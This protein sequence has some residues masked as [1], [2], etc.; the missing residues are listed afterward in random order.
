MPQYVGHFHKVAR[1]YI[2]VSE[3]IA[4]AVRYGELDLGDR[5]LK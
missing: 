4:L 2:E 3:S 1:Q 5:G